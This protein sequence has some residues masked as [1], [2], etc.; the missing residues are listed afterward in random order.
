MLLLTRTT[1]RHDVLCA[2][3]DVEFAANLVLIALNKLSDHSPDH[4]QLFALGGRHG[5]S[6]I[7]KL[8]LS[9]LEFL[10]DLVD[11][12]GQVVSDMCE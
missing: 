2:P 1:T 6:Q 12:V 7:I 10:S 8:D 9:L 3:F 11:D 4:M 5:L